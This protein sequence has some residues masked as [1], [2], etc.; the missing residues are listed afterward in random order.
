[1]AKNV[2]ELRRELRKE[3]K[4]GKISEAQYRIDLNTIKFFL[5]LKKA[6]K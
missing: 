4:A 6:A 3:F 1:M 2:A 5:R